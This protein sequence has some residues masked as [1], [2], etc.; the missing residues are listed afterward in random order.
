MA[1]AAKTQ[2]YYSSLIAPASYP[3]AASRRGALS[4]KPQKS[5]RILRIPRKRCNFQAFPES[6]VLLSGNSQKALR[7]LQKVQIP[8]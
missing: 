1:P 4:G 3:H 2:G 5:L 7:Y 6:A 8:R